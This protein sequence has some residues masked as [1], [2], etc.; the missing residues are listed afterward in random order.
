[1]TT[2]GAI[3]RRA[4]LRSAGVALAFGAGHRAG[5]AAGAPRLTVTVYKSP[6]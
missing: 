5:P 6:T 1:M 3:T 2:R 4:L